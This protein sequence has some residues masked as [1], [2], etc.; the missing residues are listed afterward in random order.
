MGCFAIKKKNTPI[1]AN[2]EKENLKN[3]CIMYCIV[4]NACLCSIACLVIIL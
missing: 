4:T 3:D 2:E 1:I